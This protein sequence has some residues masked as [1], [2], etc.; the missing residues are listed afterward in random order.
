MPPWWIYVVGALVGLLL[1]LLFAFAMK[2]VRNQIVITLRGSKKEE[3]PYKPYS[4]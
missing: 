4:R 2:R 3:Y 1:L